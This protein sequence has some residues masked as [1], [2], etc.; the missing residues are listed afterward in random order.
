[1]S[2]IRHNVT[3][4]RIFA[5]ATLNFSLHNVCITPISD[6][7]KFIYLLTIATVFLLLSQVL[8]TS[9]DAPAAGN[10]TRKPS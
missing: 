8:A 6:A 5:N 2:V 1:M 9:V 3:L 10:K 4:H 7:V